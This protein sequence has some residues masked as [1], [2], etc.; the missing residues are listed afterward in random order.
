MGVQTPH[1]PTAKRKTC[2]RYDQPG[3]AHSLTFSCYQRRP[4]LTRPRTCEWMLGAIVATRAKHN[5]HLWAYVIM[6]EH[7]HLPLYPTRPAYN[8]S[9]ILTTLKQSVSKRA[10]HYVR[11]HAPA[12]L[13]QM[14]DEQPSGR[15]SVRFWQRG[16]GYD[17]NLWSPRHIWETID[18]IHGNPVRRGLCESDADWHWSSAG[19][20]LGVA[21][22]PLAV[23]TESL[24]DDPRRLNA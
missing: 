4:F 3:H 11:V 13:K 16:G 24:P 5:V 23:D 12:F 19:A 14:V 9:R 18:Y 22:G 10:I 20:Y 8:V 1:S 2:R 21:D 6:P 7:V 17:S 15:R